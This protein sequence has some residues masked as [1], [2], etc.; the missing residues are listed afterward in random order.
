MAASKSA[1]YLKAFGS[2]SEGELAEAI[3]KLTIEHKQMLAALTPRLHASLKH[4]DTCDVE[5][6]T[7]K[8][9]KSLKITIDQK[10]KF[11]VRKISDALEKYESS[12]LVDQWKI[13]FVVGTEYNQCDES[14][15][16]SIHENLVRSDCSAEHIKLLM[17]VER[18][19]M[20]EYLKYSERGYGQWEKLCSSLSVC[21]ST[22]DRYIDFYRVIHAYPRLL[23][24]GLSFEA[25]HCLYKRLNEH[26]MDNDDLYTRLKQPLREVRIINNDKTIAARE[27]PGAERDEEQ[28]PPETLMCAKAD[29]TPGWQIA[30][31]ITESLIEDDDD[32]QY[33]DTNEE[34]PRN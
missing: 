7:S 33:E 22:A 12:D 2:Y 23:I 30:D 18:G 4:V 14:Q 20:Y 17:I 26:L 29:W 11:A 13:D 21:R 31:E 1:K 6:K 19:R 32:E 16:K 25:I 24:C 15:I 34:A 3:E 9:K 10:F 27:L 28:V 5:G 8:R